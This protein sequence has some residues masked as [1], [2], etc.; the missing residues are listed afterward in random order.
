MD[1]KEHKPVSVLVC[2][3]NE[4]ENLQRLIP[5]ILKQNYHLFELVIIND[6]S[7]DGT[8]EYLEELRKTEKRLK[9]VTADENKAG[10]DSKKYALTLGIKAATHEY[11][12]FTDADCLPCNSNWILQMQSKFTQNIDFVL[13]ISQYERKPGFLNL[14]IRSETFYTALQYISFAIRK[15]PYMGVG[16]NLAYK[17]SVFLENKGFH[18]HMYLTGG[19]DDLFVNRIANAENTEVSIGIESQTVSIPK[20]TFKEW[21][22]QKKRHYS[23][24]KYYNFNKKWLLGLLY[25]SHLGIFVSIFSLVFCEQYF[26]F[27]LAALG[28]RW[29]V[30]LIVLNEA[31][32]KMRFG[33]P[34]WQNILFDLFYPIF[35][36]FVGLQSLRNKNIQW[37]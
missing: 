13:G 34:F 21:I 8:Y 1:V 3:H 7:S 20:A 16:R 4:L 23:V 22:M 19:D 31:S 9:V 14:L 33:I 5:A 2:A 32:K 36:I 10:M 11:L 25:I 12:L 37:K 15:R 28:L 6:R 35:Y 30:M 29:L 27:G 17:K 18:P 26:N 24:G